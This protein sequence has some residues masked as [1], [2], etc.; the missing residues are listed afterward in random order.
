MFDTKV[1]V[2]DMMAKMREIIESGQ[3]AI[4]MAFKVGTDGVVLPIGIA[5][6][7]GEPEKNS[8]SRMLRELAAQPDT[9][10]V[11]FLCDSYIKMV[12]HGEHVVAR[13][14]DVPGRR[15]CVSA[16]VS[17]RDVAPAWATWIYDR[18]AAGKPVFE[19]AIKWADRAE[20]RFAATVGESKDFHKN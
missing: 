4:P 3:D 13:L 18:D 20:G 5:G 7:K 16:T 17:G 9:A 11:V 1:F 2:E 12:E 19:T 6:M 10:C 14:K 8:V 15:E